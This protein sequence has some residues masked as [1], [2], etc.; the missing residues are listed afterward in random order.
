MNNP[1]KQLNV[2]KAISFLLR[3]EFNAYQHTAK[4]MKRKEVLSFEEWL[5]MNKILEP[6]PEQS[7]IILPE[8]KQIIKP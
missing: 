6:S 7:K 5:E 8:E 4:E 3:S 1:K 2:G